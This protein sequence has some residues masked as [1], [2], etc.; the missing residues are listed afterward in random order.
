MNAD[1][2]INKFMPLAQNHPDDSIMRRELLRML[3][4]ALRLSILSKGSCY[5][6]QCCVEA[7]QESIEVMEETAIVIAEESGGIAFLEPE[8]NMSE[9]D[10]LVAEL[11]Y[12]QDPYDN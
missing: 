11:D 10:E 7:I 6:H 12:S 5:A 4:E 3:S 1:E 9:A 2:L 8:D